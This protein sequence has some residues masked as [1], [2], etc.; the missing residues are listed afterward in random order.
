MGLGLLVGG[1]EDRRGHSGRRP[2][3]W[4]YLRIS[5][6]PKTGLPYSW[7]CPPDLA[8][9]KLPRLSDLP[10]IPTRAMVPLTLWQASAPSHIGVPHV[11]WGA[12]VGE[13]QRPILSAPRA[14]S[15]SWWT[16][17]AG[18]PVWTGKAQCSGRISDTKEASTQC[19][20]ELRKG[21]ARG[22]QQVRCGGGKALIVQE[23]I[24][25]IN[26]Y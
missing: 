21:R 10:I 18:C 15:A 24:H 20:G 8:P 12:P 26:V 19:L 7:S 11:T 16:W 23:D 22:Y 17:G 6:F 1:G 9:L 4:H 3:I 14:P 25:S 5:T 2:S 13:E